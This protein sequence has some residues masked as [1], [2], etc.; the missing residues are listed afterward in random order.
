MRR[1]ARR[2]LFSLSLCALLAG[3]AG[4]AFPAP[5]GPAWRTGF[6]LRA[7]ETALLMWMPVPGATSYKLL[8]K[9]GDGEYREIYR[10]T[11][12]AFTDAGAGGDVSLHYK[13]IALLGETESEA[14]PVAEIR[15]EAPLKP[16]EMTGAIPGDKTITIRWS[17]ADGTAYT[18]VYRSQS[19]KG[20]YALLGSVQ[21][22]TYVDR[23]VGKD[24]EYHYRVAAVNTGGK[25][26][27]QSPSVR[28]IVAAAADAAE[29]GKP[30]V[31]TTRL[32]ATFRGEEKRP[33]EQPGEIGIAP[34]GEIFVLERRGVQFFDPD[35][36]PLRRFPFAPGW[37]A[38]GW[39]GF[40][41]RGRLLIAFHSEQVVRIVD[42][43]GQLAGE[44]RYDPDPRASRNNPNGVA[45][46]GKGY[47]W[48]LDGVRSQV[49]RLNEE[50]KTLD[51]IGRP[52]G[53]YAA[54][55]RRESDLPTARKVYYNPYD[56][57]LY[58]VLGVRPEIKVVDPGT[59][60]V[61]RTFGGLGSANNQFQA[62]GGLAFRR[63][64][65][66]LV[67]DIL[68][69]MVKEFDGEYR[70][71][72]TYADVVEKDRVRLSANLP[73]SIA[74]LEDLRRLYVTSSLLNRVYCF[75]IPE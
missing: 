6:P 16:P 22:D 73:T 43:E 69:R 56:G 52:P 57:K 46:D 3:P 40:D 58:I 71:V 2:T 18:N 64:G 29:A 49:I 39:A 50:G 7:G 38:A 68:S 12:I 25:E 35:G 8:R 41:S 19:E 37:G 42:K 75:D 24:R 34:G 17:V 45:I 32:R 54:K 33:L 20:P 70:Y 63:N 11:S 1:P 5:A 66:L 53:T 27:G 67:L 44:I 15:A 60:R 48:V 30:V 10:G 13:V 55:D 4:V 47:F 51:V 36:N 28:A 72:A 23:E 74:Y 14:S 61:V 62:I 9:A 26:S 59:A 65:N 31:R 21:G